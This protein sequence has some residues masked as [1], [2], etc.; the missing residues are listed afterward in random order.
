MPHRFETAAETSGED[1]D[2]LGA[3]PD[4]ILQHVLSFLPS[5]EIVPTCLLA[6]RWRDLW[7]STPALRIS[8]AEN[9]FWDYRDMHEFV[10]HL[11]LLRDS[12]PMDICEINYSRYLG[13]GVLGKKRPFKYVGTWIRYA[14]RHKAR[15]LRVIIHKENKHFELDSAPLISQ[16]LTVLEL[17]G[18]QLDDRALDLSRYPALKDLKIIECIIVARKISSQ[19]LRHLIVNDN[20]FGPG[21]RIRIS[22]PSLV[23]LHLK[24]FAGRTPVLESMPL[25]ETAHVTLGAECDDRCDNSS[26]GNCGKDTCKGCHDCPDGPERCVL[27][28]GL[29]NATDL[30]LIAELNVFIFK[31]D[32]IFCPTFSK[33]KTL[34]LFGWSVAVDPSSVVF[35][36]Q[37]SPVLEKLTLQLYKVPE[38]SQNP[39]HHYAFAH[40]KIV[41]GERREVEESAQNFLK[42][43]YGIPVDLIKIQ[44]PNGSSYSSCW[45]AD[46][47]IDKEEDRPSLVYPTNNYVDENDDDIYFLG[48]LFPW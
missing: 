31:R 47:Y 27:L 5:D 34:L 25:L 20:V 28:R 45:R 22:I 19:S 8:D 32:L 29:S 46:N 41:E 6:R 37:H 16:H 10:N 35:L 36:L 11:L 23:S 7:K 18:V 44:E 1:Q 42:S 12:E 26:S 39:E 43:H 14:L 17:S 3:L 15:V 48:H 9:R 21:L 4:E 38:G 33:L 30:K 40:L 24:G 13:W 2:L